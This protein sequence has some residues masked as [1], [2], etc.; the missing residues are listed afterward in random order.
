MGA[1]KIIL[2]EL[3][4]KGYIEQMDSILK[5]CMEFLNISREHKKEITKF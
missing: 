2:L 4:R 5:A 3:E 1:N